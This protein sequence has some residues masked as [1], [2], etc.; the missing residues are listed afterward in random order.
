MEEGQGVGQ[1]KSPRADFFEDKCNLCFGVQV[2]LADLHLLFVKEADMRS[3]A[4]ITLDVPFLR[5]AFASQARV[6]FSEH[7]DP[8]GA[9]VGWND[10]A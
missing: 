8:F 6:I 1:D 7:L 4:E 2:V 3:S 9:N 10:R 5:N